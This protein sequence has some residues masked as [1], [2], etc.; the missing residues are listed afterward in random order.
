MSNKMTL[1]QYLKAN[2]HLG[3]PMSQTQQPKRP[4]KQKGVSLL[5]AVMTIAIMLTTVSDMIVTSAVQVELAGSGRDRVKAEYLAKS[6]ANLGVLLL[7]ISFGLDL[8]KAGSPSV[9]PAMKS[10]RTDNDSS[11]WTTFNSLPPLGASTVALA[12][13]A[14]SGEDDPFQLKGLLSER[15]ANVMALFED[16]FSIKITDEQSKINVNNCRE[17]RCAETISMLNALFSCPIEKAFLESK[18]INPEQLSSQI[19]EFIQAKNNGQNLS[20]Y[21]DVMEEYKKANP[22]YA[23][24]GVP[25]DSVEELKLISAWDDEIHEVFSPYLTAFLYNEKRTFSKVNINTAPKELMTCLI[26]E[27]TSSGCHEKFALSW[28]K[29]K[30][31]S[32]AVAGTAN[33]IKGK[34]KSLF[35]YSEDEQDKNSTSNKATWFDVKS[36]IFKIA[37]NAQTGDQEINLEMLIRRVPPKS[38]AF[39]RSKQ[40]TKR[41]YSIVTWKLI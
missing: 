39:L 7:S 3:F 28:E 37:V 13:A 38:T 12:Q 4:Q 10:D 26:P 8:F 40:K 14:S 1:L 32:T 9:P 17:G 31:D 15:I 41:S 19:Y 2:S 16:Q 35:C 29:M 36:D 24:K 27:S 20:G 30:K 11:L 23:P 21:G 22:P 18:H 6:G 5:I 33:E 34:L 25:L